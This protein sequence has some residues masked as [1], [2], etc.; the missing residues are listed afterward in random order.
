MRDAPGQDAQALQ[1]LR[2]LDLR[3]QLVV[4]LFGLAAFFH[5]AAQKGVGQFQLRGPFLDAE[6]EAF[7][8]PAQRLLGAFARRNVDEKG[9]DAANFPFCIAQVVG[10]NLNH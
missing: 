3:L 1:P 8:Y 5:F 4:F 6:F 2:M 7:L 9:T 10:V